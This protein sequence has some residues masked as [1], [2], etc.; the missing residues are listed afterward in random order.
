MLIDKRTICFIM[1]SCF[2]I[3]FT[4][5]V[6]IPAFPGAEGYG[7]CTI[8]GRGGRVIERTKAVDKCFEFALTMSSFDTCGFAAAPM[9]RRDEARS[10][11]P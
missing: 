7:A 2:V 10:T 9:A 8:G 5:G 1:I 3:S 6:E 11:F 4:H